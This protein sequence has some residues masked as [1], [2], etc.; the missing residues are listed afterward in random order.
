M[1]AGLEARQVKRTRR[2]WVH[3]GRHVVEGGRFRFR[4]TARHGAYLTVLRLKRL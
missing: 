4:A 3:G 2:G 1:K